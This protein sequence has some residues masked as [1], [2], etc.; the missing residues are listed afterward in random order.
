MTLCL[1]GDLQQQRSSCDSGHA[2]V[3]RAVLLN[4]VRIGKQCT[5]KGWAKRVEQG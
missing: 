3:K 2:G 1:L 4:G 5:G